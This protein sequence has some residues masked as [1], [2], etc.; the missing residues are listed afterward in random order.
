MPEVIIKKT[1]YRYVIKFCNSYPVC[2]K[3]GIR[4]K[5]ESL[6]M[7]SIHANAATACHVYDNKTISKLVKPCKVVIKDIYSN[8]KHPFGRV[9]KQCDVKLQ[10]V[11]VKS[12]QIDTS[13]ITTPVV[14]SGACS[15]DL[16]IPSGLL[17]PS[18]HCYVNSILQTL[19]RAM[20]AG[21][22]SPHINNNRGGDL[23]RLMLDCIDSSSITTLADVKNSLRNFNSFF[24]WFH[25][26]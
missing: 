4:D 16:Y 15:G 3:Y 2:I 7:M 17:N 5:G 21:C 11:T 1:L 19:H 20:I 6:W 26:T 22:D 25:S 14:T 8:E 9:L 18:N 23:V 24:R 10:D 13:K 12:N